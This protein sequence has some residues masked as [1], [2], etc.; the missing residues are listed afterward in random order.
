VRDNGTLKIIDL[1]FGKHVDSSL[2]F[3]KSI[4]LNWWC[5]PPEDFDDKK[6]DHA[7][8]VYFVGKL[9]EKLIVDLGLEHFQYSALLSRMCER[10]PV[11]RISSFS[12]V[13]TA[14]QLKRATDLDFTYTERKEY[15]G[16]ADAMSRQITKIEAGAKYIEDPDQIRTQLESIYRN[17]MLEQHVPDC[18]TVIRA[19]VNGGFHYRKT[20]FQTDVLKGFLDLLRGATLEKRR[21]ALANLHSR[22]NAV[23]RYSV[24]DR[25]DDIP[26]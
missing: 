9:F 15:S 3:D 19:F 16:F 1:G 22:L 13:R 7:T 17:C 11:R 18:A 10:N 12:E 5:E 14:I 20:G 4:S 26:F 6:Y 21:V 8:E 2:D 24:L 25:D 23:N